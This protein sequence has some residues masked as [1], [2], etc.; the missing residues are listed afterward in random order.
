MDRF[1]SSTPAI[2]GPKRLHEGKAM[3]ESHVCIGQYTHLAAG[4]DS[5]LGPEFRTILGIV[6]RFVAVTHLRYTI[7]HAVDT[8]HCTRQ[9]VQPV[10]VLHMQSETSLFAI[11]SSLHRHFSCWLL[12]CSFTIVAYYSHFGLHET[13]IPGVSCA[14]IVVFF[15]PQEMLSIRP[16]ALM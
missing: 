10:L 12:D 9:R 6:I 14:I 3:Q 16:C 8:S 2:H 5:F 15:V 11:H 7:P 4:Y 13:M 1:P